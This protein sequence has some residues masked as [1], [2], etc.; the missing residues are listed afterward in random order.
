MNPN[1][2]NTSK[3]SPKLIREA[4]ESPSTSYWLRNAL[5]SAEL[6][7]PADV[8]SDVEHLKHIFDLRLSEIHAELTS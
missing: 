2:L 8:L 6:R 4:L 1:R 7:D 5:A 3:P